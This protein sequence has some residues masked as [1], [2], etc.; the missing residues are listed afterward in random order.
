[1]S[2]LEYYYYEPVRCNSI[3][4]IKLYYE[5]AL[6]FMGSERKNSD[7]NCL[8]LVQGIVGT[9]LSYVGMEYCVK[10]RGPV[11]TAAFSPLIQIVVAIFDFSILHEQLHLGSVLGSILVILGLY[12]LL[13]G[14]S[15]EAKACVTKQVTDVEDFGEIDQATKV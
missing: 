5:S 3:S 2:V 13:W 12:I 10:K 15:K 8:I 1:M 9:R 4:S 7:H 11:F 6:F 14:K